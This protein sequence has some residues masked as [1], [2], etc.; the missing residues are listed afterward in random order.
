M[1]DRAAI[2]RTHAEIGR[3]ARAKGA[4]AELDL[5]RYLRQWWPAAERSVVTG[6]RAGDHVRADAGD[7]SGTPGLAWQLK[8]VATMTDKYIRDALADTESQALAAEADFGILV[9][10]RHGKANPHDWFAWLPIG[11]LCHLVTT[12]Y[13]NYLRDDGVNFGVRLCLGDLV[14]LLI[15]AGYGNEPVEP[16]QELVPPPPRD[17][18][19]EWTF[20]GYDQMGL[21]TWSWAH[22]EPK[23]TS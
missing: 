11:D 7:I 13:S 6:S 20:R 14:S 16:K 1:T 10:R 3:A 4:K 22:A 15:D 23:A 19:G 17:E 5:A 9:Q 8:Y 12:G 21:P 2:S 18:P